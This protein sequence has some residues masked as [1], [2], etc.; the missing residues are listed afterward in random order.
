MVPF[1]AVESTSVWMRLT[2]PVPNSLSDPP[3]F[4]MVEPWLELCLPPSI[5]LQIMVSWDF[6]IQEQVSNPELQLAPEV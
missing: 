2:S 5:S 3:S 6:F 1:S 4:Q